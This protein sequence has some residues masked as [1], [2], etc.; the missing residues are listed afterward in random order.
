MEITF[1]DIMH[2]KRYNIFYI[3]HCRVLANNKT[4]EYITNKDH[5]NLYYNIPLANT[6]FILLGPGTSITNEAIRLLSKGGVL[7]GFTSDGG[8]P[9]FANTDKNL[10]ID[11]I[12]PTSEY[13]AS[14]Y[15]INFIPIFYD[16]NKRLYCA[17]ALQI[18]RVNLVLELWHKN[19]NSCNID[20]TM[21]NQNATCFLSEINQVSNTQDLLLCEARYTKKLYSIITKAFGI[22]DFKRNKEGNSHD[23][24]NSFLDHGN[25]LAYG[26]G[27]TAAWVLG[28]PFALS[29]LHG[30]TRRGALVFDLAD[31][32]KDAIVMPLAFSCAAEGYDDKDYRLALIEDFHKNEA[33]DTIINTFKE[34][35]NTCL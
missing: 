27:A 8:L 35:I 10:D 15:I 28:I 12:T 16:A 22:A 24:A 30:K 11:F 18:K 6:S 1:N 2:S 4:V 29:V 32:I 13:R 25:Y 5:V 33:L 14:N 9:L 20:F 7:I 3:E 34:A 19:Y 31:I 26:L 17:K 23:L 21:L